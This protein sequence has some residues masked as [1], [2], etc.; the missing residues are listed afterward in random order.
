MWLIRLCLRNVT[1]TGCV[2]GALVSPQPSPGMCWSSSA[3]GWLSQDT[4]ASSLV[5]SDYNYFEGHNS[6]GG[7]PSFGAELHVTLVLMYMPL[8][9]SFQ[10]SNTCRHTP[11][12]GK[13][14]MTQSTW[15]NRMLGMDPGFKWYREESHHV[16][17]FF[18]LT[19]LL[20]QHC[21]FHHCWT[22]NGLYY[23]YNN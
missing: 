22:N 20:L 17:S 9:G 16:C 14:V 18:A 19:I 2:R 4:C 7:V 15:K 10:Y 11:R 23:V 3:S 21:E 13:S 6:P 8:T 5:P 12:G 1:Q